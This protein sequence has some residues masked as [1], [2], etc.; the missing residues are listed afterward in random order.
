MFIT[1]YKKMLLHVAITI[2]FPDEIENFYQKVLRFAVQNHFSI[3]RETAQTIFNTNELAEVY[4][5]ALPTLQF[6]I[7]VSRETEKKRFTHV[8]LSYRQAR[9]IYRKAV[10]QGY[11]TQVKKKKKNDT[12]FIWDKSGNMFEIKEMRDE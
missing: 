1:N 9:N 7:F 8:C 11:K 2:H 6:E 4:M 10:E 3:N 12:Y 5:M